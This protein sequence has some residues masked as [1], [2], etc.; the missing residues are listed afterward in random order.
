MYLF[1]LQTPGIGGNMS[2]CIEG[3]DKIPKQLMAFEKLLRHAISRFSK[4]NLY[5]MLLT[6]NSELDTPRS[7][8]GQRI[9]TADPNRKIQSMR[10]VRELIK[11]IEESAVRGRASDH[12]L[13]CLKSFEIFDKDVR[14][15]RDLKAYFDSNIF[16]SLNE[17]YYDPADFPKVP[18]LKGLT[19]PDTSRS[20]PRKGPSSKVSK[21]ARDHA[22]LPAVVLELRELV[23]QW[24]E[25]LSDGNLDINIFDP[26]SHHELLQFE[27]Y[28]SFEPILRLVPDVFVKSYKAID[29]GRE[30]LALAAK[31][32]G[33]RL[34]LG[35]IKPKTPSPPPEQVPKK[36][37]TRSRVP[38]AEV[39]QRVNEVKHHISIINKAINENQEKIV[40]LSND[41]K[42]LYVREK[43]ADVLTNN[44]EKVDNKMQRAQRD[45]QKAVAD[46]NQTNDQMKFLPNNSPKYNELLKKCKHFEME[47]ENRQTTLQMLEFEK[48]VVQEDYLIELEMRPHFI[49]FMGDVQQTIENL[50]STVK[51]K[52]STKKQLEKQIVLIKTAKSDN[53][54]KSM[55]KYL[56]GELAYDLESLTHKL[57]LVEQQEDERSIKSAASGTTYTDSDVDLTEYF[58]DEGRQQSESDL[59]FAYDADGEKTGMAKAH[60]R[61][62]IKGK[63]RVADSV[64]NPTQ[65]RQKPRTK[66]S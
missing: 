19:T 30:W 64:L 60:S 14:Y 40:T 17:E 62:D 27:N 21:E 18:P 63:P 6:L 55:K 10:Q 15:L 65:N 12:E 50:K 20:S 3:P 61:K 46:L 11:T 29:M 13:R 22:R 32:Y 36:Q 48:S 38:S 52:Q 37:T 23:G 57:E 45:F 1:I 16:R 41:E 33:D 28:H 44:F 56:N 53:I 54:N 59:Q 51:E 9:T 31:I 2:S 25:L 4:D 42:K 7:Q 26:D 8:G 39:D 35:K 49:H 34:P 24:G 58:V 66:V 5:D 43:R 47:I